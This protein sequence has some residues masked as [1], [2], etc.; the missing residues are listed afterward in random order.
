MDLWN[1][2]IINPMVNALLFLYGLLFNNL[3]LTIVVFTVLIRAV[4][5][6]LTWQSQKAQKK[7]SELQQSAEWK[8]VQE[9]YGKDR[10]KMAQEQM[11]LYQTAGVNPLG[12]CLPMLI[13]LPI[14]IGLYQ[15]ITSAIAASPIQLY[16]LSTHIYSFLPGI[17]ALLPIDNQ[18]L[19]MNLGLPD[20]YFVMPV[21]VAITSWIQARVMQPPTVADPQMA[22][23]T[24]MTAIMS[25]F[26]FAYF[27]FSFASG[28]SV[29]FITSNILGILQYSLTNPIKW[30]NIWSLQPPS[31]TSSAT[32]DVKPK[33][34]AT[35][36][37]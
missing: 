7:L 25:T 12:G 37:S 18:F 15:A 26:F 10:E 33:K 21:L 16:N 4:V 23:T 13:Q 22:Q 1:T 28:L 35:A 9:K 32:V 19:W 31:A 5:F 3:T 2:L 8:K 27:A 14:L 6:P 24:N 20:P 11:K 17:N 29:Y 30:S 36:K 34:R